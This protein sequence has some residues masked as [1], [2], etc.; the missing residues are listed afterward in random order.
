[1]S[2]P[3]AE[4]NAVLAE[5]YVIDSELGR[6]GMALV[7]LARDVKHERFVA[8][9]TLRPEIAMA[10]GRE[11]F[12]REI[13][14]A[15]RLQHPNILP[16]Y[17]SGDAAGTLYYVMPFVEGESLRERLER[18]PQLPLD[19]ALQITREV[20]DALAYAHS[21]DVVHRDIKP[22]NIMLSGGHAMVTDFGIARAIDAAGGDRLTETGL[23]IGTPAY[24]P[25]EQSAGTGK[26]DRRSDIYSLACV[27]YETLAGQPPFTGPTA[28]AIMARHSLDSVPRLKVVR[29]AIPDDVEVVIERALEKVP[30]DRY[31]TAAQFRDA[32]NTASTGAVSRVTASR[33][34]TSA[35]QRL[36]RPAV[37]VAAA[38]ALVAAG[39]AIFSPRG[40][41]RPTGATD[42]MALR[43]VAVLYF[44]DL[45]PDSSLGFLA[46][47][48]TEGLIDQLSEV[49]TLTVISR[50]GVI[51]FRHT[52]LSR[53]SVARAI[54]AGTLVEGSVEP[55]RDRV[56]VT[57]R[58]IDGASGA[59]LLRRTS[60]EQPAGN[61]LAIR[62]T[63]A[64]QVARVLRE[65]LGEEVRLQEERGSTRSTEAWTTVQQAELV[66]KNAEAFVRAGKTDSATALFVRTD[67]ILAAAERN[68]PRWVDPI[69][70]RGQLLE[71]RARLTRSAPLIEEGLGHAT[72]ALALAPQDTRAIELRGT[73]RYRQWQ[74]A[75]PPDPQQAARLLDDARKDLEQATTLDPTA[76]GA[77]ATLSSLYYQT[78]DVQGA[79]L[80]ARRAYEEDAYL[81]NAADILTRLFHTSYD[82][83]QQRQAQR[84]CQEGV[85]RF[86]RDFR[87]FQCQ[88]YS[89][90]RLEPPEVPRAWRLLNGLD[91]LTPAPQRSL[92]HVRN[93][94]MVAA[95]IARA[96]LRD[97]AHHVIERSR[98]TPDVDPEQAQLA[99]EAFVRTILG[100]QDEAIRLL[101]R[102]VAANPEHSFR[103]GGDIS[104]WW[105]DLQKHPGFQSLVRAHS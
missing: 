74:L 47:G 23:A 34:R 71:R 37:I 26:V 42:A 75:R 100:E 61:L 49:R 86:P 91:S 11:R 98:A 102:Y 50:N 92:L 84:W 8:L 69:I 59:D 39:W 22:E 5:H 52:D 10:L 46:D 99:Y 6:G 105:R 89:M 87:F 90:T 2:E 93:Q 19:D 36:R 44:Q 25:P 76:A 29:E 68:D 35:I 28:Q 82:L 1:M 38:A 27:L 21:H 40:S 7:Y 15:A 97:S 30:A 94:M 78:K 70:L 67:S 18:E 72:R 96:G 33:H 58:L 104:W 12:L 101:Q 65:R 56:R 14:L 13:K 24:M 41:A 73:L 66:R 95:V 62:D 60:F 16:V 20:A 45:S 83:D 64:V 3:F 81:T 103:V 88:I 43:R 57:V 17:D 80:A 51:P 85:R 31:Q 54:G 53:D 55:V 4:L 48:L 63:L 32:L 77:F 9:K 79:A